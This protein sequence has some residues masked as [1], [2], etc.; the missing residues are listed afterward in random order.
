MDNKHVF[1]H[2]LCDLGKIVNFARTH[3]NR[4]NIELDL[5]H[6]RGR[7]LS[8]L[9]EK[10]GAS[11]SELAALMD[12]PANIVDQAVNVLRQHDLV[13]INNSQQR[14]EYNVFITAAGKDVYLAREK[15]N[16]ELQQ[17]LLTQLTPAEQDSLSAL[18]EKIAQPL[19]NKYPQATK[20]TAMYKKCRGMRSRN[21]ASHMK[22]HIR[23][24]GG[25][26][27]NVFAV[28]KTG[29]CDGN[30]HG[31]GKGRER[32]KG[33]FD[34]RGRTDQLGCGQAVGTRDGNGPRAGNGQGCAQGQGLG[35]LQ[36]Q[37]LGQGRGQSQGR[38]Q[39]SRCG[40]NGGGF[41]RKCN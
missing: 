30:G 9:N 23:L 13:E 39:G 29:K 7:L 19:I 32:G 10:D 36:G 37:G 8:A 25:N 2:K 40:N 41:G 28:E 22:R 24:N 15:H 12:R 16:D 6:G 14:C 26:C 38:R 5:M 33:H 4:G 17:L 1:L 18:L 27:N 35:Q 3:E 21:L 31:N 11:L 20:Y 34:G